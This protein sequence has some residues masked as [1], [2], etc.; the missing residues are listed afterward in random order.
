MNFCA[1]VAP[2]PTQRLMRIMRLALMPVAVALVAAV[3]SFS[4]CSPAIA[5]P[6]VKRIGYLEAGPF[7]LFDN[8]W[9]AFRDGMGKYDDLRCEYPADARLSPGWQPEQM[10]RLPELAKQLLQRKDLDLV[11]GM[12]TAA[13]KACL[14][15]QMAARPFWAWAWPTPLPLALSK[16]QKTLA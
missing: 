3:L 5:N 15:S 16:A 4:C 1:P 2:M 14:Q 9:S 10:R 7:W 12:G 11:V 6:P 8:T 13:V